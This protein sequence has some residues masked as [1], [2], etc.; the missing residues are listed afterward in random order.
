MNNIQN[1]YPDAEVLTNRLND[2]V[3]ELK[4]ISREIVSH[5]EDIDYDPEKLQAINSRLDM[6]YTLERNIIPV[7]FL[8]L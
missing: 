4:D 2:C 7:I 8:I 6:I 1:V 5:V 3:I